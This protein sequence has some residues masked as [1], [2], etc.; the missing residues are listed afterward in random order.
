[1]DPARRDFSSLAIKVTLEDVIPSLKLKLGGSTMEI[2]LQVSLSCE[3]FLDCVIHVC[4]VNRVESGNF[5]V[6]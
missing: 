6:K 4:L 5:L 3:L 1:M 2:E